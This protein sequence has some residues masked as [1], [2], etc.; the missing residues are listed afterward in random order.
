MEDLIW[1]NGDD[2]VKVM[3]DALGFPFSPFFSEKMW[4]EW[5]IGVGMVFKKPNQTIL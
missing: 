1:S 5:M 4:W 2:D 3:I